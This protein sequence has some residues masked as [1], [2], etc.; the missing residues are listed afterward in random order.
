MFATLHK[1][2]QYL[3]TLSIAYFLKNN[4]FR[5]LRTNPSEIDRLQLFFNK[6]TN[7][8]AR[9]N[10]SGLF[11]LDVQLWRFKVFIIHNLP[12]SVGKV[13]TAISVNADSHFGF[14]LAKSLFSRGGKRCF[15]STKDYFLRFLMPKAR[16]E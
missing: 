7:L 5:C 15:K 3:L 11:K 12:A 8:I 2:S 4:L 1:V 14:F 6:L 16:V 10:F 9:I 13:F